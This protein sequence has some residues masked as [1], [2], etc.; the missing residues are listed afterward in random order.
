MVT[1]A[2]WEDGPEYAPLVRPDAFTEP[3]IS[4]LSSAPP[5]EQLAAAVPNERPA[6]ADPRESVAPLES[7]V[8]PI[9]APRDPAEPFDVVTTALTSA[10]S[11]W[12][13]AHWAR[14]SAPMADSWDSGAVG[15]AYVTRATTQPAAGSGSR[16]RIHH[17]RVSGARHAGVVHDPGIAS[18]CPEHSSDGQARP[19]RHHPRRVHLARDR[20]LCLPTL[21][22]HARHRVRALQP[23][24]GWQR[25]RA[26]RLHDG[27]LR[28][29][30]PRRC[31]HPE[32]PGVIRRLVVVRRRAGR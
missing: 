1:M 8:P 22:H 28:C 9:E 19:G 26:S 12:G 29:R 25:A 13:A 27:V 20:W 4:P 30:L 11:A 5:V 14:P 18:A 17:Q 3:T 2:T 6:F 32:L 15:P 31:G 23:D 7:L 10:D 21:T 16:P 24:G